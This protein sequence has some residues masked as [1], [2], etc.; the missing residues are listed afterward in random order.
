MWCGRVNLDRWSWR[1]P[2]SLALRNR[3]PSGANTTLTRLAAWY[4]AGPSEVPV[5]ASQS[6]ASLSATSGQ[7]PPAVGA[8]GDR[9]D[10][11]GM[12]QHVDQL[13][14]GR[15][16][17]PGRAVGAGGRQGPAV[18]AQGRSLQRLRHGPQ[19]LPGTGP[20]IPSLNEAGISAAEQRLRRRA[21]TREGGPGPGARAA[22]RWAGPWRH[23]RA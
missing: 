11:A 14:A 9:V 18:M 7:E 1:T 21:R 17:E 3:E 10:Q 12:W 16:P 4:A 23:P 20:H 22:G 6:R 5:A 8:E 19:V 15:V 2:S 13:Q